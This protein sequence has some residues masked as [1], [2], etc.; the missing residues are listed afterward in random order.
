MIDEEES[1]RQIMLGIK[2]YANYKPIVVNDNIVINEPNLFEQP[3]YHHNTERF[4]IDPL[5]SNDVLNT[6]TPVIKKQQ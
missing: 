1:I 5:C 4:L 6:I 3:K 2:E